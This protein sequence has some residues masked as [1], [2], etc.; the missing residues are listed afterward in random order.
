MTCL[1]FGVV[2]E[3]CS[4]CSSSEL[5]RSFSCKKI[6]ECQ[7]SINGERRVR[8]RERDFTTHT[9]HQQIISLLAITY[10]LTSRRKSI[11]HQQQKCF[12]VRNVTQGRNSGELASKNSPPPRKP[13]ASIFE[14]GKFMTRLSRL[15]KAS[16]W[17]YTDDWRVSCTPASSFCQNAIFQDR[18]NAEGNV[19]RSVL[20][21]SP[22]NVISQ[23]FSSFCVWGM[24]CC[25]SMSHSLYRWLRK[26][27]V[28]TGRFERTP[29]SVLFAQRTRR[30]IKENGTIFWNKMFFDTCFSQLYPIYD[31]RNS[32][33]EEIIIVQFS[34]GCLPVHIAYYRS[35]FFKVFLK[36][37][38]HT[39]SCRF[40]AD[41]SS[42]NI[43]LDV[44]ASSYHTIFILFLKLL[45]S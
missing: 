26:L 15:S 1:C 45:N 44:T 4:E 16:G 8:E 42:Q 6:F 41:S 14:R 29:A 36:V 32:L 38:I 25:P 13:S 11:K 33:L 21:S 24:C 28:C 10:L 31:S 40:M 17:I 3:L 37:N 20:C 27:G 19:F 34:N 12:D 22:E 39:K 30:R 2:T 7:A 35:F 23:S 43:K 18:A 5:I 9:Q